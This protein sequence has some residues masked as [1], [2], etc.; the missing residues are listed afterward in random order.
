MFTN[1]DMDHV[2]QA[3]SHQTRR[4]I[5]DILRDQ[6]G[7]GVG[8]L[9]KHFELKIRRRINENCDGPQQI[10]IL[11]RIITLNDGGLIYEADPRHL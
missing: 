7:Q 5:L 9:A 8:E 3:L 11:N 1:S 2:F 10:R 4:Q 6:A